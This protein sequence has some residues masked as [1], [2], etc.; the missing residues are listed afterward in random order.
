MTVKG[1]R[2]VRH[3]CVKE[4]DF[5]ICKEEIKAIREALT[6]QRITQSQQHEDAALLHSDLERLINT[7]D[8]KGQNEGLIHKVERHDMDLI[9]QKAQMAVI[10]VVVGGI[11]VIVG[12]GIAVWSNFFK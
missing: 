8:G 11:V 2:L 6:Q 5:L 10:K 1:V 9:S 7:L 4:N 3:I 12:W